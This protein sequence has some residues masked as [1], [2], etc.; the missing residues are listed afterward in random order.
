MKTAA[1]VLAACMLLGVGRPAVAAT[2][3]PVVYEI[4]I[5]GGIDP[6]FARLPPTRT[7]A[8]VLIWLDTPGGLLTSTRSIIKAIHAFKAIHVSRC[9]LGVLGDQPICEGRMLGSVQRESCLSKGCFATFDGSPARTGEVRHCNRS[10]PDGGHA[11]RWD[12]QRW[13]VGVGTV[14]HDRS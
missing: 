1:V 2:H 10:G 13:Q 6:P 12:G 4:A 14:Q 5:D 11:H 3:R 9:P 8:T 7:R